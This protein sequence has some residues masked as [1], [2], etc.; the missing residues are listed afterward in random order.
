M[1]EQALRV[2]VAIADGREC[3]D[4]EEKHAPVTRRIKVGDAGGLQLVERRKRKIE[5]QEEACEASEHG[6]PTRCK[7]VYEHD[8]KS[9]MTDIDAARHSDP[10]L[11]KPLELVL[12]TGC[13]SGPCFEQYVRDRSRDIELDPL[14]AFAIQDRG[15][16]YWFAGNLTAS[17]ADF[18]DVIHYNIACDL[19]IEHRFP[20]ALAA[21]QAETNPLV[22][23]EA[24]ALAYIALGTR[25]EAESMLNEMLAKDATDGPVNIAE[26]YAF[27]GNKGAALDWL[28]RD[29]AYRR[30]GV[31]Y[32]GVDPFFKP[33]AYEPRYVA[34]LK[35]I[36]MSNQPPPAD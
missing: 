12:V 11:T 3:L 33:L 16:G 19:L 18:F 8:P 31:V 15:Y 34:L 2:H 22:R 32:L 23:R 17:L 27:A 13:A 7:I 30:A 1:C 29:Y 14:N 21:A 28:E 20:E 10:N 24:L 25:A 35:K 5:Q 4:A 36:G 26:V 9:A 6:R